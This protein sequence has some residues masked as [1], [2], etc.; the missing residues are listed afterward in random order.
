MG[1]LLTAGR[2]LTA[3]ELVALAAP[4]RISATNVK[5][6]LTRMVAQGVLQREGRTRKATYEP[7]ETQAHL[8]N[9]IRERLSGKRERRWDSTWLQLTVQPSRIRSERDRLHFG[10]WFAGFRPIAPNIYLRPAWPLPWAEDEAR[11]FSGAAGGVCLRGAVLASPTDL[12]RLYDL[13]E[14]DSEAA[15]LASHIRRRIRAGMSPRKAFIERMRVGGQAAP[16]IGH[17][18]RLP[19]EIWGQRHGLRDLVQAFLEFE[20]AVGKPATAFVQQV[21]SSM[22]KENL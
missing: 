6:H 4:F 16:L 14:L 12:N 13:D 18:P 15:A 3:S 11:R 20:S 7:T 10:L 8:N 9:S 17:D 21:V 19:A 22:R 2:R 1:I 5:S